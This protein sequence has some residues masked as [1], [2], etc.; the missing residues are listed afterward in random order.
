MIGNVSRAVLETLSGLSSECRVAHS[1][2][3]SGRRKHSLWLWPGEYQQN[4]SRVPSVVRCSQGKSSKCLNLQVMDI[5][6]LSQCL[7]PRETH[8]LFVKDISGSVP[9][10]SDQQSIV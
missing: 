9:S 1:A 7:L 10:L 8:S 2:L 5:K 4:D 3:L 6:R